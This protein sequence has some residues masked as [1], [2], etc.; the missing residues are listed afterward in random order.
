M[1]QGGAPGEAYT[2]GTVPRGLS[3]ERTQRDYMTGLADRMGLPQLAPRDIGALGQGGLQGEFVTR[4]LAR[5]PNPE[6][7]LPRAL[8]HVALLP[9]SIVGSAVEAMAGRPAGDAAQYVT[10][11]ALPMALG[12]GYAPKTAAA[13]VGGGT[14]LDLGRHLLRTL[15]R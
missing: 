1:P 10:N 2:G 4:L 15:G 6:G 11:L 12:F 5:D 8:G 3:Y 14:M 7:Q 13:L 9:S